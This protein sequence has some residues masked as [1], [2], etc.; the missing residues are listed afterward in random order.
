MVLGLQTFRAD[1][2]SMV[3]TILVSSKQSQHTHWDSK[4][5]SFISFFRNLGLNFWRDPCLLQLETWLGWNGCKNMRDFLLIMNLF[6]NIFL[7][8]HVGLFR[9]MRIFLVFVEIHCFLRILTVPFYAVLLVQITF[10]VLSQPRLGVV[11]N[12]NKC[13]CICVMLMYFI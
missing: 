5:T 13:E 8:S 12:Y 10:P 1:P 4:F 9:S 6:T 3:Y 11:Q 2:E 7:V